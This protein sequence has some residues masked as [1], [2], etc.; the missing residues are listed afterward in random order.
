MTSEGLYDLYA[1]AMAEELN[2]SVEVW[3]EL[4]DEQ[5]VWEKLLA[6]IVRRPE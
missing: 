4:G 6:L 1:V 3:D 2:C 5:A